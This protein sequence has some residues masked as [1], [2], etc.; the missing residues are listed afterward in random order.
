MLSEQHYIVALNGRLGSD[1]V[2]SVTVWTFAIVVVGKV[3]EGWTWF[4]FE[5]YIKNQCF[6]RSIKSGISRDALR[7]SSITNLIKI[8]AFLVSLLFWSRVP[9]DCWHP[10]VEIRIE[11]AILSSQMSGLNGSLLVNPIRGLLRAFV[12]NQSDK[13]ARMKLMSEECAAS[14]DLFLLFMTISQSCLVLFV[15]SLF[16]LLLFRCEASCFEALQMKSVTALSFVC[17]FVLFRIA[18]GGP[19][20]ELLFYLCILIRGRKKADHCD[21]VASLG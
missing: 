5:Q 1:P 4:T 7:A 3:I 13:C 15:I 12:L 20:A 19:L 6:R 10:L 9:K 8:Q 2:V 11:S 21:G 17:L 14:L 16:Q 18:S